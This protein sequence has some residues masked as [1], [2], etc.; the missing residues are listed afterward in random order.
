ML[1]SCRCSPLDHIFCS[2]S[3]F[4]VLTGYHWVIS[5]QIFPLTSDLGCTLS[6]GMSPAHGMLTLSWAFWP[7]QSCWV[8]SA[9]NRWSVKVPF[10]KVQQTV[11][12]KPMEFFNSNNSFL[13]LHLV[14]PPGISLTVI[15]IMAGI[16]VSWAPA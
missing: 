6:S 8:F 5:I 3:S 2:C 16:V 14:F 10:F 1:S 11:S 12:V 4:F 15:C 13:K 9:R 7:N